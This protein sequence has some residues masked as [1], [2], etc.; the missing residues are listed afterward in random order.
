ME[1]HNYYQ[2]IVDGK[3]KSVGFEVLLRG[4]VNGHLISTEECLN[5]IKK[6]NQTV[7]LALNQIAECISLL[8]SIPDVFF[9][10]NITDDF[11]LSP[12]VLSFLEKI[13]Y[14]KRSHIQFEIP[15][16][17]RVSD[18]YDLI[19]NAITINELG[20]SLSLDDFFSHESSTLPFVHLDIEFVKIDISAI[21]LFRHNKRVERLLRSAIYYCNISG[22]TSIAEGVEEFDV[23]YE[24]KGLGIDLFQGYLFS[25]AISKSELISKYQS[26]GEWITHVR[27]AQSRIQ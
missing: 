12:E 21:R 8:D 4:W 27:G 1:T 10:I 18:S 20:Y 9:S 14:A 3:L 17:M 24:L 2:P 16:Q 6:N 5:A 15:E 23:F 22:C 11:I 26:S 7:N 19:K 25:K 13:E